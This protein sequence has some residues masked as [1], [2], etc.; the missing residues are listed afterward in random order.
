MKIK[1]E[2]RRKRRRLKLKTLFLLSLTL[3][4]NT[5]AWFLYVTTVSTN[6]T[7]HVDAW[8]VNFE[9]G[10]QVIENDFVFEIDHAYPGMDDVEKMVTVNNSGEKDAT[11]SYVITTAR[12]FDDIYIV[13]EELSTEEKENLTGSEIKMTAEELAQML[14]EDFPFE[15][16]VTVSSNDLAMNGGE[17]TINVKFTWEYESGDDELDTQYGVDSY[18]YYQENTGKSAIEIKI[19]LKAEQKNN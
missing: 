16:T 14:T 15:I 13:E 12:I 17:A 5:Y 9:V 18:K 11:L 6:M 4:F 3:I 7:V 19:K 10:D 1:R 2:E 8:S